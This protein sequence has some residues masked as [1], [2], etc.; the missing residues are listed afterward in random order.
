LR[1]PWLIDRIGLSD[2]DPCGFK[3]NGEPIIRTAHETYALETGEDGLLLPWHG[4]IYCNPP[5]SANALWVKKCSEYHMETGEDVILLIY[6]RTSTS[7]FQNEVRYA[8][9]INFVKGRLKFLN[10]DG[11]LESCA[12]DASMLIAFG[13]GAYE[14]ICRV[15]GIPARIDMHG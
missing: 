14:R 8:T 5:Y 10:S 6:T 2:L 9:G 3:P 11:Q 4:S 1:E 12:P 13:E 15:E 7:Y